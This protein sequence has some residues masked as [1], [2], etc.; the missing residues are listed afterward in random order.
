MLSKPKTLKTQ[1]AHQPKLPPQSL[2]VEEIVLGA[3]LLEKEA[4]VKVIQIL[5]PDDFY[6]DT[7]ALI[8]QAAIDLFSKMEPV[9]IRTVTNQLRKNGTL[10]ICGGA[11]TIASLTAKLSSAAN[12][13]YHAR[14]ILELSLKRKLIHVA[15]NTFS[16]AYEDSADVFELIDQIE[17]QLFNIYQL[18]NKKNSS[19]IGPLLQNAIKLI[20]CKNTNTLSGVP[21]GFSELDRITNGWQKTD[22]I[23]LAA[24]P[25]MGKTSLAL[26]FLK[27]AAISFNIP[28]A[29]F[30]LEMSASQVTNRLIAMQSRIPHDNIKNGKLSDNDWKQLFISTQPLANAKI[31]IDDTPA[32]SIL[33]L[34]AKIR[35]LIH[36]HN[37]Q[38]VVIDYLQLMTGEKNTNREQ[39][40]ASISRGLKNIAKETNIPIIALSQLS[41]N[42]E[43][44][45]GDKRPILSDLRESGT[46]EQDS[47]MVCFLYRPE[48]YG[49]LNDAEGNPTE[50]IAE[51]IIAKNRNGPTTSIKL[52]FLKNYTIFDNLHSHKTPNDFIPDT[53]K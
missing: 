30:S 38:L 13:E 52:K 41:R 26:S 27:N 45:G 25:S 3:I 31:F 15:S 43:S 36:E 34:R 39:E 40:I 17:S 23:I 14:I 35:K 37:V 33:E 48:Y 20:Q 9:D 7:H 24:R 53:Y 22:L 44:R 42:V 46:I 28:V 8:Y 50:N 10:E 21:S 12:I 47:D 32:I 4:L 6:S 19:Q 16:L 18:S 29:L 1:P 49:I 51:L 11:S 5:N 2:E